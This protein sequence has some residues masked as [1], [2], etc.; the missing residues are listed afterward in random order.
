MIKAEALARLRAHEA[1]L[2]ALGVERLS[3]FGSTARDDASERSDV[4]LAVSFSS[5]AKAGL[6]KYA[7]ISDQLQRIMGCAIDLVCEPAAKPR[8][9]AGIDKD[10]AHVF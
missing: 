10:R 2:R 1:E 9:Q 4:D 6:F 3:L 8:V 7:I 5:D